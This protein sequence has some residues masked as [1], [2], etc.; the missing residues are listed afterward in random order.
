MPRSYLK[1]GNVNNTLLVQTI[2]SGL[3]LGRDSALVN[4]E[5]KAGKLSTATPQEGC[6]SKIP[7]PRICSF[8]I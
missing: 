8:E 7:A 5:L 3:N 4:F 1:K 2:T 6:G